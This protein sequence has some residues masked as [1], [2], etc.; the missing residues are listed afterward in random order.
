MALT[1][2]RLETDEDGISR[3]KRVEVDLSARG[4]LVIS[5]QQSA[6]N[7][8]HR[9]SAPGYT[10]DWHVAG[11]P[12]LIIIRRGVLR[13][14]LRDGT[15]RDFGPGDQFIAADRLPSGAPFD[16]AHHGHRAAVMGDDQLEAVHIKL[17]SLSS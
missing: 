13:I 11:D 4:G 17:A 12:T 3:W 9:Q 16:P 1:I 5:E 15:L 6:L 8:R 14:E 2:D 7:F 10:S